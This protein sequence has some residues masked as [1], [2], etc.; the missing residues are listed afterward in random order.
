MSA[1]VLVDWL[2]ALGASRRLYLHA[3]SNWPRRTETRVLKAIEFIQAR[4]LARLN[5]YV[6]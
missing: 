4:S 3:L 6:T 5:W 1:S 2:H